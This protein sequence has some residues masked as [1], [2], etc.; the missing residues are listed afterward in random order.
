MRRRR[1]E[2]RWIHRYSR[3][4][5]AGVAALGALETAYL[6][7]VKLTGGDACPAEGCDRVLASPYATVFG[8]PLTV[9]GFLGYAAMVALATAPLW[10]NPD[11]NKALR[12]QLESWTWPL[13]FA[14]ATAMV[15][16]SGYLMTV[17]AFEIQAFCPFCVASA[18]FSLSLFLL[19]VFGRRWE[20]WGQLAFIGLIVAVV[21]LTGVM[22]V[23]A[24]IR[25]GGNVNTANGQV[26]PPITLASGPAE[27]ALAKHL[28][29]S[30]AVMYGAWWCP[31]CHDQKE[32]FGAEAA[33]LI[34]YVECAE[35]GRNAQ[36]ALC[37]SK[38]KVTGFPTWEINGEFYP[39]A[40]TLQRLGELSGY[41]GPM[42]FRN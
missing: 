10:V 20:D 40:Q 8:L 6:T 41:Q 24:P 16:F 35:D 13:I 36:T 17:M 15:V 30:G 39:G 7:L 32:V 2:S 28:K 26:G 4:L 14:L 33:A 27:L 9:F 18:I 22:A 5:L 21:T 38:A 37:R 19:A 11:Q 31:H 12:Q 3:W 25:A 29:D 34:P 23:Y 1:Q 42:D